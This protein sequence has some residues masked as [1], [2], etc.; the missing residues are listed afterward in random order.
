[1]HSHMAAVRGAYGLRR[2]LGRGKGL[3]YAVP[4]ARLAPRPQPQHNSHC[5]SRRQPH[6]RT[7]QRHATPADGT[8]ARFKPPPCSLRLLVAGLV[9]E[10][11]AEHHQQTLVVRVANSPVVVH[12]AGMPCLVVSHSLPPFPRFRAAA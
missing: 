2:K 10:R 4:A 8:V 9:A 5:R 11:L 6:G 3:Y 1:M 12:H 7:P